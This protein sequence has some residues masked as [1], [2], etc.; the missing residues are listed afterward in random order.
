MGAASSAVKTPLAGT[1]FTGGPAS[2]SAALEARESQA[3]ATQYTDRKF[4]ERQ[5]QEKAREQEAYARATRELQRARE[6][7][8]LARGNARQGSKAP[9]STAAPVDDYFDSQKFE[10]FRNKVKQTTGKDVSVAD[11]NRMMGRAA[12]QGANLSMENF[13]AFM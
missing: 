10:A 13:K 6:Q 1:D 7:E 2:S 3:R 9:S 11:A 8:A 4:K 12:Q 5:A